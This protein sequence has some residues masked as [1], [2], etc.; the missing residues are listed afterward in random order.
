MSNSLGKRKGRSAEH[1]EL[2]IEISTCDYF[3]NRKSACAA[4]SKR[5][6]GHA[7]NGNNSK[8]ALCRDC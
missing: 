5:A 2:L 4:A 1:F 8:A 7:E 3:N 6:Q